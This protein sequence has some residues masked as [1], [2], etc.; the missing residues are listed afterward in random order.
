MK[1]QN[2]ESRYR[3][4][5]RRCAFQNSTGLAPAQNEDSRTIAEIFTRVV[6]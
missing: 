1:Q 4:V 2:S 5:S 3:F 6:E